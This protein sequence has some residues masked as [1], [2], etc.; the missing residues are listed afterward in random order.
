LN[1]AGLDYLQMSIDNIQPDESSKKSL[2][3]LDQKQKRERV[4]N[5]CRRKRA[6]AEEAEQQGFVWS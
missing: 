1:R 4:R 5:D 3:V 2:K 6:P